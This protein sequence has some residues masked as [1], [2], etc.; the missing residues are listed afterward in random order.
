VFAD[1]HSFNR[2]AFTVARDVI[3]MS[4]ER[5]GGRVDW[6][7][8][9]PTGRSNTAIG[10]SVYQEYARAGLRIHSWPV[11][12]V[13]DSLALLESF[14]S[15]SPPELMVHPRCQH[16]IEA[17]HNFKRARRAGQFID[18]P[19]EPQHPYEDLID[20]LRGVIDDKYPEGRALQT[21][22]IPVHAS[23]LV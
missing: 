22:L 8:T 4:S 19:I 21:R 7:A 12:A 23:T 18:K 16:L 20:A 17:F 13:L 14:V 5:C 10:V 9:D 6:A 2:G 3:A 15:I 1:Y 11:K